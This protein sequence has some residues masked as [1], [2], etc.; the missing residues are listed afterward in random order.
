MGAS[1]DLDEKY[2]AKSDRAIRAWAIGRVI[3]SSSDKFPAGTYVMDRPGNAG[4][5]E[6]AVLPTSTLVALDP[7]VIPLPAY[8]GVL[9]TQGLTAHIGLLHVGQPKAGETV[10][11]SGAAGGVGSIVGQIAKI[12]GCRTVGIAGGAKKCRY[13]VDEFGFDDCIDY[14]S[15]TLSKAL[16]AACPKGID[17][18]FDNVGGAIL[19]TCL[20]HMAKGGRIAFCGAISEYNTTEPTAG[21]KNYVQILNRHLRMEGVTYYD[22]SD[23]FE[24]ASA[25]LKAWIKEGRLKHWEDIHVGLENFYPAFMKLFNG[26]SLGKL[27]LQVSAEDTE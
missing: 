2:A 21:L 22:N 11:I 9:G 27:I 25:D 6:Y 1:K 19:D 17:V 15:A 24:A 20:L 10:V 16:E 23:K 13:V 18:F 5:Q 7:T 8:L 3:S 4:I 26:E 14:K 12:K